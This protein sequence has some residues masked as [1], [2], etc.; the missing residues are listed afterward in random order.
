MISDTHGTLPAGVYRALEGVERIYHC[1]DIGEEACLRE[2][3]TIA[4][5]RAVAGNMDPWPL[6]STI[7][8]S[9]VDELPFG[10][11]G[12]SHGMAF[13]HDNK[14][15]SLGLLEWF[16]EESPR[17]IL[18]GHSHV[19]YVKSHGRT[20]VVN[21]GSASLPQ[22]GEAPSVGVLTYR[23]DTFDLSAEIL[24]LQ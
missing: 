6:S 20:L 18:F 1:G 14:R 16:A 2:L 3:E 12:V 15:I 5:V 11:V 9:F 7:P 22:S 8:D 23:P 21:P 13:G 24:Y 17:V 19:P 10:R 4:L